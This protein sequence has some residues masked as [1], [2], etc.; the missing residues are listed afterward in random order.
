M[1][2]LHKEIDSPPFRIVAN[3]E[4]EYQPGQADPN[5]G[6]YFARATITR[7]DG[8]PVCKVFLIYQ[9]PA[10][11]IFPSAEEAL[12]DAGKRAREA[13]NSGFPDC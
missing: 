2:S 12:R 5:S 11:A 7:P 13:I 8:Q 4:Q 10:G 6:R 1:S 3:A 9:V